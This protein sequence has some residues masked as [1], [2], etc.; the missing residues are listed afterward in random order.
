MT[1]SDKSIHYEGDFVDGEYHGQGVYKFDKCT[2]EGTFKRGNFVQG[3]QRM[4]DGSW[5]EGGYL[6][7]RKHGEGSYHFAN[8]NVYVGGFENDVRHGMGYL[9][10]F[11]NQCKVREEWVKGHRKNFVKTTS[12]TEELKSQ[13]ANE[14]YYFQG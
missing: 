9:F 1:T 8:G 12:T 6:N 5:Y 7:L 14:G 4:N 13:L 11:E 2:Y 3:R 10:D